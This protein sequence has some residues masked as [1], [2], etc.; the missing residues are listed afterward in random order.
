MFFCLKMRIFWFFLGFF[1]KMLFNENRGPVQLVE[2]PVSF[3][4][5]TLTKPYLNSMN[6]GVLNKKGGKHVIT[7]QYHTK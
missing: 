6:I 2:R 1:L 4:T 7:S 3:T 5:F